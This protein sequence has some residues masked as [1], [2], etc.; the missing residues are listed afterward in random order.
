MQGFLGGTFDPI[1]RGHLAMATA[2]AR[3]CG[4]RRVYFVPAP[5]PWHRRP[6]RSSY[7]DR[8]AM[9]ALAL[10]A[11]PAFQPLAVP[12]RPRRPTY[13]VDQIEWM[14]D[15]GWGEQFCCILGADSFATLPTWKDYRRLLGLCD[16]A[17]LARQG[18]GPDKLLPAI[19]P[20]MIAGL[21]DGGIELSSGHR[22]HWLNNFSHPTSATAIR[23][24]TAATG[25]ASV[26]RYL[27]H[28]RLYTYA[29]KG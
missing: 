18:W 14:R 27:R 1:H 28:A 7:T 6:P 12:D 4:L 29:E 26:T 21:D 23:A 22:I 2:A 24:G 25:I 3:A 16:F 17:V 8:Y 20:R 9:V 5:V 10:A 11:H 15:H 19:P 13:A